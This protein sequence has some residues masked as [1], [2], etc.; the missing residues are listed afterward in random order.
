MQM[1]ARAVL[2]LQI[3]LTNGRIGGRFIASRTN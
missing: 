2:W 3:R 1:V